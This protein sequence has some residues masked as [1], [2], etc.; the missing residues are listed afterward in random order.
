MLKEIAGKHHIQTLVVERPPFRAVLSKASDA[1]CKATWHIRVQ[2]HRKL[3]P[4]ID[5]INKLAVATTQIQHRIRGADKSLKNAADENAP[6]LQP[7]V[8]ICPKTGIVDSL[9]I[10]RSIWA[11]LSFR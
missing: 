6:N 4:T 9:K 10:L 1:V 3:L 2:I 11:H 8:K 7:I 5:L